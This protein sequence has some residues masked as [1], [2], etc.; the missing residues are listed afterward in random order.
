[1]GIAQ[2]MQRGWAMQPPPVNWE[3]ELDLSKE[4]VKQMQ[5]I[6][7]N[8][9]SELMDIR[10]SGGNNRMAMREMAMELMEKRDSAVKGVL[11]KKQFKKYQKKLKSQRNSQM[12]QRGSRDGGNRRG[13]MG[14]HG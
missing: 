14:R 1:M 3:K 8:F 10:N 5:I 7:D 4:Q 9:R 2:N 11:S 6:Q 13:G 12:R